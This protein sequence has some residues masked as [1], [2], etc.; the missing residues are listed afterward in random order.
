MRHPVL[1]MLCL[2][3]AVSFSACQ[4]S[5]DQ[6]VQRALKSVNVIDESNLSEIMLTVGDPNEAVTYFKRS[7]QENPDRIDLKRGPARRRGSCTSP[8]RR[9][10]IASI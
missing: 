8:R 3:S 6:D 5:G 2:G 4:K 1:L 7:S 9:R 10:C